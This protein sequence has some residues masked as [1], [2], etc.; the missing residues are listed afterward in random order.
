MRARSGR[1]GQR[2]S[3][4][5]KECPGGH[6]LATAA[7]QAK[8]RLATSA[9][10]KSTAARSNHSTAARNVTES[11]S[12]PPRRSKQ[13]YNPAVSACEKRSRWEAGPSLLRQSE[14][15]LFDKCVREGHAVKALSR[16]QQGLSQR[17][18]VSHRGQD[19]PA[20]GPPAC[21]PGHAK[22]LAAQRHGNHSSCSRRA[23]SGGL[24]FANLG[25]SARMFLRNQALTTRPNSKL[26]E[27]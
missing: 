14:R 2:S 9:C 21:S 17:L 3:D 4:C 1:G 26:I 7:T 25:K 16:L 24:G 27:L 8:L 19:P 11:T 5:C 15:L 22:A 10:E 18:P 12:Q 23:G 6:V 20:P 13:S